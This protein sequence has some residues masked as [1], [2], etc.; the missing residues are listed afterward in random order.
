MRAAGQPTSNFEIF[1][2]VETDPMQDICYLH[3]FIE[4][5]H[6]DNATERFVSFFADEVSREAE[7]AAFRAAWTYLSANPGAIIYYYS[8]YERTTYRKLQ[9]RYPSVC[10]ADDIENLFVPERAVDLYFD[11]V[12]PAMLWPTRD[13][14]I[15]TLAKHLGF[16]WRD[17]D[18]SGSASIEWYQR[19]CENR[20]PTIKTR[21]LDYNEDDCRA[22]RVLLDGVRNLA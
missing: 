15:K 5:R 1:F 2:D 22:T 18:P 20:D 19:Y 10:S 8:K 21:I 13:H 16:K 14:S 4:R 9:E 7:E 6:G 11:V 12:E 3:G 17:T